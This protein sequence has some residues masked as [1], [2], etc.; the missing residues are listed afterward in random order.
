MK[1]KYYQHTRKHL[2][3]KASLAKSNVPKYKRLGPTCQR[4]QASFTKKGQK[5]SSISDLNM[6]SAARGWP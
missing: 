1:K 5:Q 2:V 3:I 4:V 6:H